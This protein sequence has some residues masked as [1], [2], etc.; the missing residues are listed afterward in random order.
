[1][2]SYLIG[3]DLNRAGQDYASLIEAITHKSVN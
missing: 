2:N 3:Y 1:M